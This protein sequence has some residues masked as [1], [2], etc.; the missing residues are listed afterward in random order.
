MCKRERRSLL[1]R[2]RNKLL[3][4]ALQDEQAVL[5]VDADVHG[6]GDSMLGQML[7]SGV[8]ALGHWHEACVPSS[9]SVSQT[10]MCTA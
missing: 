3:M 2:L 4:T 10:D 9:C 8:C 7:A 5:W 1:A 6:I